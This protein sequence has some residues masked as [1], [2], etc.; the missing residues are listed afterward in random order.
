MLLP[1]KPSIT[2]AATNKNTLLARPRRINPIKVLNWLINKI[3]FLP[4]RSLSFPVIGLANSWQTLNI[5]TINPIWSV[6]RPKDKPKKGIIGIT[7]LNPN[8]S[9]N[10]IIKMI[11]ICLLNLGS[12]EEVSMFFIKRPLTFIYEK[13]LL[14]QL[15]VLDNGLQLLY[16]RFK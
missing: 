16:V 15:K 14:M 2:R 12:V 1:I 8:I 3:G 6:L 13:E 4:N 9:V 5:L 11:R 10:I 7:M